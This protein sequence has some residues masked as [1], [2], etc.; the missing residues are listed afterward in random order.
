M[1]TERLFRDSLLY[2][3]IMTV[4][5]AAADRKNLIIDTDIFSDCE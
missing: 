3:G 2:F 4:T 1:H 5:V